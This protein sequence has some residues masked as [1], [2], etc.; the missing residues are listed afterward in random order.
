[1]KEISL[2]QKAENKSIS[3]AAKN[4]KEIS[5]GSKVLEM[6]LWIFQD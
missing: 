3:S 5:T 4:I 2:G 1:M 6:R